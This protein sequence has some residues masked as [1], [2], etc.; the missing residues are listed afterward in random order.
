MVPGNRE[1]FFSSLDFNKLISTHAALLSAHLGL[2]SMQAYRPRISLTELFIQKRRYFI[3]Y[4]LFLFV[5]FQIT[6]PSTRRKPAAQQG[7]LH[8]R[9][10]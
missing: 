6:I 7:M 10:N 4:S 9:I 2:G 5:H 3:P 1:S 8:K